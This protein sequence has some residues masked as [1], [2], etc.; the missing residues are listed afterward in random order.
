LL[1][2]I[3]ARAPTLCQYWSVTS[4]RIAAAVGAASALLSALPVLAIPAIA[5]V[6]CS[7][8]E[9]I[10]ARG[11]SES[12]GAGPTGDAFIDALRS[13]VGAKSLDVYAVDYPATMDFPTAVDGIADARAHILS[14]AATCPQ[15]KMV[16]GGFSQGAAVAGFVTASAVPVDVSAANV[17]KPMPS[18]VAN[19]VV[20]VALFGKPSARFMRA[21]DDPS[22]TIGPLYAAKTIDL[23]IDNDLV[24]DPA[25]RSFSAH[26]EYVDTGMVDKAATF[27]ATQ[28]QASWATA[29]GAIPAVPAPP[30]TPTVPAP[31]LSPS[32]VAPGGPLPG[33]DVLA[34][35]RGL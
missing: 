31:H 20:A 12:P 2:V 6:G 7:D 34:G 17:P 29:P 32:P 5:A 30:A 22:I 11:T 9:V 33:P 26:N 19:H 4:W 10:F 15:T 25:G 18:D 23:C 35:G 21:I 3:G 1:I 14:T 24:C 13:K 28:L 16:L 8:A 27:A